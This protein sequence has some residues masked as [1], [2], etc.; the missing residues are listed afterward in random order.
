[1]Q[2]HVLYLIFYVWTSAI[3]HIGTSKQFTD[4]TVISKVVLKHADFRDTF[5][6]FRRHDIAN[7]TRFLGRLFRCIFEIRQVA[8]TALGTCQLQS[9]YQSSIYERRFFFFIYL[10]WKPLIYIF[11][12]QISDCLVTDVQ[13]SSL[14]PAQIFIL[15]DLRRDTHLKHIS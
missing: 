13:S 12:V 9:R 14:I 8:R 6:I 3:R 10:F 15:V 4:V 7:L 2:G 5:A 1:M 11:L